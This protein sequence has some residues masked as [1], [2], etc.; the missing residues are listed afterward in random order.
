MINTSN[1]IA[2]KQMPEWVFAADDEALELLV[3]QPFTRRENRSSVNIVLLLDGAEGQEEV[4]P[5]RALPFALNATHASSI[6]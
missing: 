6:T 4:L 5:V 2:F 3:R 1:Q